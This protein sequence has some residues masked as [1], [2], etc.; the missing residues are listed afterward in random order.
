[1]Q[2]FSLVVIGSTG[3]KTTIRGDWLSDKWGK[4][5]KGWIKLHA[6]VDVNHV[7]PQKIL[8]VRKGYCDPN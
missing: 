6:S 7:N 8:L 4:K 5:R 3:F 1:M 2:S